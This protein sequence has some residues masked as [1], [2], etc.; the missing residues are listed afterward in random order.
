ML[1]KNVCV[2]MQYF[3]HHYINYGMWQFESVLNLSSYEILIFKKE[4][5]AWNVCDDLWIG[6]NVRQFILLQQAELWLFKKKSSGSREVKLMSICVCAYNS[7]VIDSVYNITVM[8]Q[9]LFCKPYLVIY[10]QTRSGTSFCL[11]TWPHMCLFGDFYYL[12]S[13]TTTISKLLFMY[14][15]SGL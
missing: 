6:G 13:L 5:K 4:K 11:I 8:L 15:I 7:H 12:P 14:Q 1:I 3:I 2:C 9:S 10:T